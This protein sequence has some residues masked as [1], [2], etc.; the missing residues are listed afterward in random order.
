M[1]LSK[2]IEV[3]VEENLASRVVAYVPFTT[4]LSA[5]E[6]LERGI[7]HRIDASVWP[8]YS[9]ATR[10]QLLGTFKFL[11]LVDRSGKPTASLK[12]LVHSKANRKAVLRKILETSYSRIVGLDLTKMS[13]KQFDE[14][15]REYG[16]TGATHKKVIS[17]FLRAAK[18]SELPLS[19]LLGR[20]IRAG[21][22]RKRGRIGNPSEAPGLRLS[23]NSE[24][25]RTSKTIAL[26]S[27]GN[28]T[29]NIEGSFV[30]MAASD[31]KFIS[32]LIDKLQDYEKGEVRE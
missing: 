19:P 27:G 2:F 12:T 7:H 16:M 14:A 21:G 15:M 4:F 5:V 25:Q 24:P 30:E 13:P 26:R 8:S 6:M 18:Y 10:S 3:D 28:L 32:E 22:P 31:R 29:L 23:P 17:F 1:V 9:K 11:G 20:K